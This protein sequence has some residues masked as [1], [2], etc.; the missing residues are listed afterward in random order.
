MAEQVL[1]AVGWAKYYIPK[2]VL[3][4][5]PEDQRRALIVSTANQIGIAELLST[6]PLIECNPPRFLSETAEA[7]K[8]GLRA[9][10]VE[11]VDLEIRK[12][13]QRLG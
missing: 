1:V 3:K 8:Q 2:E 13:V 10:G 9:L 4:G 6:L 12:A 5:L 7:L 11:D